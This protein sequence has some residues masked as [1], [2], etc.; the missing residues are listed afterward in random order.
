MS[1]KKHIHEDETG[2]WTERQLGFGGDQTGED[3]SNTERP[4]SHGNVQNKEGEGGVP[5]LQQPS[6]QNLDD[7]S[8][9]SD[10]DSESDSG[11]EDVE[12]TRQQLVPMDREAVKELSLCASKN[13]EGFNRYHEDLSP[14]IPTAKGLQAHEETHIQGDLREFSEEDQDWV[15]EGIAE[16]P[17]ELADSDGDNDG[18][19]D[20]DD[21]DDDDVDDEDEGK[22]E[23][24]SRAPVCRIGY[25]GADNTQEEDDEEEEDDHG[26]D[27]IVKDRP[28]HA[29]PHDC[30]KTYSSE[31]T[32]DETV[33]ERQA[34]ATSHSLS[35]ENS[36]PQREEERHE[37]EQG[38]GKH[39][40]G[41]DALPYGS[42]NEFLVAS[43]YVDTLG[44][45]S[46]EFDRRMLNTER[47][48]DI[49]IRELDALDSDIDLPNVRGH[50]HVAK[51]DRSSLSGGTDTNESERTWPTEILLDEASQQHNQPL[52]NPS[53]TSTQE[54]LVVE[55]DVTPD[56]DFHFDTSL[57][58][59]SHATDG[60]VGGCLLSEDTAQGGMEDNTSDTFGEEERSWDQE[61]ERIEAFNRFYNDSDE[62]SIEGKGG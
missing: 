52:R 48:L 5:F 40:V 26:N 25:M 10:S 9:Y 58:R 18:D 53:G 20:Y 35:R 2:N 49:N 36:G 56:S 1:Y 62:N 61:R 50:G 39:D 41:V 30:T 14:L 6:P 34:I 38:V 60:C 13:T 44:C 51:A 11:N 28:M 16:Y 22:V 29:K 12:A 47:N 4:N 8:G 31:S 7:T 27:D 3:Q 42:E 15:G 33:E 21:D 59:D 57:E 55:Q 24:D 46:E 17:T 23:G 54:F 19:D 37:E 32:K 43:H 45:W